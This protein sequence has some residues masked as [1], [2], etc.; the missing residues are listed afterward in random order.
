MPSFRSLLLLPM[1]ALP[2]LVTSA[3][4][5]SPH[6]QQP[7]LAVT[8][9][10][11]VTPA[12]SSSANASATPAADTLSWQAVFHDERLQRVISRALDNNRDLRVAVLNIQKARAGYRMQRA[13]LFPSLNANAADSHSLTPAPI[14]GVGTALDENVYSAQLAVPAWQVDL[15]G[16][17]QSETKTAFETYLQNAETKRAAQVSLISETASAWLTLGADQ[18]LLKLAQSTL[19]SRQ[20]T[21]GL[22]QRTFALGEASQTDLHND[23][24]LAEQARADVAQYQA[25]VNEDRDALVLLAG[26][27]IPD[28]DLPDG[29][30]G[31]DA[32]LTTLPSGVP[33]QVLTRRPDVLAAEHAIKAANGDIGAAR[34]AF[35]PSISLTADT[36]NESLSLSHLFDN[37]TGAWS[38]TPA[39]SL[40]I[41]A[42][43]Y[44]VANLK[45]AKT[46]RDIAVAQ[47]DKAVQTAFRDVADALAVRATIEDRLDAT[48]KAADEA[49]DNLK[50]ENA[51]YQRG[52]DSYIDQLDAERTDY[53]AQQAAISVRLLR[54][55]NLVTLY[56]ALGGGAGPDT[57]GKK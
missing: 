8:D 13:S 9:A 53:S 38:F 43:G 31:E 51:R 22:T 10:W 14:S 6:Y 3:C 15:F 41:F 40:P 28:A 37:H 46:S 20:D 23:E 30:P 56:G 25:Q 26:S 21:L 2:V 54:D 27:S 36:G 18:D 55:T 57:T 1:V 4:T 11:P 50:L 7:A 16:R 32:I 34:A 29:M 48:R 17:V 52:I 42:G 33:S 45:S 39:V 5:L 35:F 12:D 24:I 44:N 47:Y 19:K 49:H